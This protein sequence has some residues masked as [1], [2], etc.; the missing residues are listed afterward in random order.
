MIPIIGCPVM[1]RPIQTPANPGLNGTVTWL[2]TG[3]VE[4]PAP[5]AAE[6]GQRFR[7]VLFTDQIVTVN[8]SWYGAG[9]TTKRLIVANATVASTIKLIDIPLYPGRNLIEIVTTT[10]PTVFEIAGEVLDQSS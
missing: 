3:H 1:R 9:S 7:A 6:Q 10:A 4:A 8:H 2:D 5:G